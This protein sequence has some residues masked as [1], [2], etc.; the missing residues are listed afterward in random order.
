MH[1]W[2]APGYP[3]QVIMEQWE[4]LHGAGGTCPHH[5]Y[6]KLS[7]LLPIKMLLRKIQLTCSV[8]KLVGAGKNPNS[9][10]LQ[11]VIWHGWVGTACSPAKKETAT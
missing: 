5:T 7:D 8:A 10:V 11:T 3:C 4:N 2:K 1:F 9:R 6:T